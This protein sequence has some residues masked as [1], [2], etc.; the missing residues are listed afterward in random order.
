MQATG[1]ESFQA[2]TPGHV[3]QP[4]AR[5]A[6]RWAYE[7]VDNRLKVMSVLLPVG[8][9]I[10]LELVRVSISG[11]EFR[12]GSHLIFVAVTVV[13]I[14]AFALLMFRLIDRA[15][16]QVM[17]QN[18]ELAATNAVSSAV[19]GEVGVDGIIDVVLETV[20]TASGAAEASVTIFSTEDRSPDEA[21]ITRRRLVSE[22]GV[23]VPDDPGGATPTITIPLTTGTV[24]VGQ[25]R[26]RLPVGSDDS[27]ASGTLQNIGHQLASAIQRAQLVADLNRRK[28]EG[29]AFYDVLLQISNQ[30]APP[31]ILSAVVQHAR[32]MMGSDEAVLSLNEEASRSVQ[33]AGTLEGTTSF[34][35]GT[36]CITSEVGPRHNAH[37]HNVACPVRSSPEW[38]A[39]MTVPIR[40]P[41]GP[42]GELWIG[43][44]SEVFFTERDRAFLVTLSGL[45]AIAITSAQMRENG[46][47]RAVLAERG[48]IAREMHD[49]LAQVL[50]VT[51]LRLRALD[52]REEV[53]DSPEIAAELSAVADICQEAY[54]DVRE[55]ILG[56]RGSGRTERGLLDNL[57][58][59]LEKYSQ[60]CDIATSL[61]SHLDHDLALSPR[62]E[63]QVIRVI[64]EALTNVRKHSGATSAIVHVTE[65]GSS[66][67]FVVED[68]G[69]GFNSA[70]SPSDRDGFGLYTMR[71]RMALL[72]G[73][74][75]IDS[76]PGRGTRVVA[77][78][79]ER[80]HPRPVHNEVKNAGARNDPHPAG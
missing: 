37:G 57:S 8:F 61:D 22:S 68:D 1:P 13:S 33:F 66:T 46:R 62:C 73:S 58:A 41:V 44:R 72:N 38:T 2:A 63:V 28:H 11:K 36:A 24:T 31:D 23:F 20:L 27:L 39:N 75:T 51:H 18:R 64:Q 78:V 42:L 10:A 15:Q 69:H 56:L 55:S 59:Y 35:D 7:W 71:E 25:M 16:R 26:L 17:R 43:R 45:A 80:S 30:N 76:A 67:T 70:H 32:D 12:D 21:V 48:R 74:L 49:S 65:S 77:D 9:I 4:A 52:V 50:G 29:H 79:P 53:R 47:Q 3:H 54:R 5:P 60:Q 14:I 34:A 19:Q 6:E 40:G